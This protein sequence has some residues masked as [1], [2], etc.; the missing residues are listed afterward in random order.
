MLR[1]VSRKV[2]MAQPSAE[3]CL[4]I[5]QK[6][7]A[8]IYDE[9]LG[10]GERRIASCKV[11]DMLAILSHTSATNAQIMNAGLWR[12]WNTSW[13]DKLLDE[14]IALLGNKRDRS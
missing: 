6:L 11:W 12:L 13:A 7:Q 14:F 3:V 8:E 10:L 4:K 5:L 9:S 2:I 1:G